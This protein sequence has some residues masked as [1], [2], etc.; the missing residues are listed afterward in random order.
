MCGPWFEEGPTIYIYIDPFL[1]FL[2]FAVLLELYSTCM[3]QL[4]G[5]NIYI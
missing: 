1:L 4:L 2:L 3:V 5:C